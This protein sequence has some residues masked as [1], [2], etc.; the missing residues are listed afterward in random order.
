VEPELI[1][2]ERDRRARGK[3]GDPPPLATPALSLVVP[4]YGDGE[5]LDE[6]VDRIATALGPA[7]AWELILV[8]DGSPP[9]TWAR[10]V[11][12]TRAA[13]P[14]R[15]ISLQRNFGQHNA[16][17]AGIRA[18]R[19][20]VIVT[21]DDD[22]QNP[23]EEIPRLLAMLEA[24]HDV[25]YGVP[26]R[27]ARGLGRR[28]AAVVMR[29]AL[30]TVLGA[31]MGREISAFR[32]FRGSLRQVFADYRSPYVVIDVLLS[33]ATTRVGA[34]RVRHEPRRHGSSRYTFWRLLATA[35][36]LV[37][38]FSVW[39]L[40]LASIV[41]FAFTCLGGALLVYV[42][43]RYV[44]EG[45]SVPG[46]PFLASIVVIFSGAQLFALGV[47]GEYLARMYFRLMDRPPYVVE[48]TAN[49]DPES[50]A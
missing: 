2:G 43:A 34:V 47:M 36:T 32:A 5:A 23:P 25:V 11:G 24:G 44:L 48:S 31:E 33:W 50:P 21:L 9:A 29:V 46:F 7:P 49:L 30:K 37:T 38:G 4:V 3:P 41:G 10:I 20:R 16:L 22:L 39:P 13:G 17:L 26:I 19:G 1:D 12:L 28:V 27:Q 40:R 35:M 6:L 45:G 8:N 42:L 14:V 15:G 18:A